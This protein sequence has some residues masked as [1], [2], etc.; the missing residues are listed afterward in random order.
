M[1]CPLKSCSEIIDMRH[2][3]ADPPVFALGHVSL[4]IKYA[5]SFNSA[6]AIFV[7]NV[8]IYPLIHY[9]RM[10]LQHSQV[11][12][13]QLMLPLVFWPASARWSCVAQETPFQ[14]P[15]SGTQLARPVTDANCMQNISQQGARHAY[16]QQVA[17]WPDEPP[18]DT[19]TGRSGQQR[20]LKLV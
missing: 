13:C 6:N 15:G 8:S 19:T 7:M 10:L 16:M 3:Y 17:G 9:L 4:W 1:S 14:P 11:R 18:S 20:V 12:H 2:G 5:V